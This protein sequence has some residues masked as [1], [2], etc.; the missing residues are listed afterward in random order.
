MHYPWHNLFGAFRS[1]APNLMRQKHLRLGKDGRNEYDLFLDHSTHFERLLSVLPHRP[2]PPQRS[3]TSMELRTV[4]C[5][6]SGVM[7]GESAINSK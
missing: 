4:V 1:L 5:G 2:R 6:E 7:R 3:E